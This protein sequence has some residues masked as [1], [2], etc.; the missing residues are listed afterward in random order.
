M[1]SV[2]AK[3]RKWG[4]SVGV[5]LPKEV[6]EKIGIKAGSEVELLVSARQKNV[7]KELFGSMKG[8]AKDKRP[9]AEFLKEIDRELYND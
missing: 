4:N 5:I 7:L 1:E 2:V 6:I 9:I 3:A 8:K